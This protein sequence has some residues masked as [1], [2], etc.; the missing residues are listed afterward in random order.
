MWQLFAIGRDRT[1]D[2]PAI[3]CLNIQNGT[4][5]CTFKKEKVFLNGVRVKKDAEERFF[6]KKKDDWSEK[7]KAFAQ[8]FWGAKKKNVNRM[9]TT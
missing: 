8:K 3:R 9:L 7:M 5:L 2:E 6:L 4:F 1:G